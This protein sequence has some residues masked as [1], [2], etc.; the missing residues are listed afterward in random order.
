MIFLIRNRTIAALARD[1]R[2]NWKSQAE[3]SLAEQKADDKKDQPMTTGSKKMNQPKTSPTA[4]KTQAS[5]IQKKTEP[6]TNEKNK[7][8]LVEDKLE[9]KK[10]SASKMDSSNATESKTSPKGSSL[11]ATKSLIKDNSMLNDDDTKNSDRDTAKSKPVSDKLEPNS[12][13]KNT[14]SVSKKELALSKT[15]DSS[16]AKTVEN[17]KLTLSK[18]SSDNAMDA[19]DSS[20]VTDVQPKTELV[21]KEP[22]MVD[23]SLEKIELKSEV[24]VADI[25]LKKDKQ[26]NFESTVS[27]K[28]EKLKEEAIPDT[29][30]SK[31]DILKKETSAASPQ[32]D[33]LKKEQLAVSPKHEVVKK[34]KLVD[35]VL[36]K[37][38][39]GV[40]KKRKVISP[41]KDSLKN[42]KNGDQPTRVNEKII[43][44]QPAST[45]SIRKQDYTRAI[46]DEK[47][48]VE[49]CASKLESGDLSSEETLHLLQT[50][51]Q[52]SVTSYTQ[53]RW[54]IV[55]SAQLPIQNS[56]N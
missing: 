39:A 49:E 20:K 37:K 41:N 29:A 10:D 55:N 9:Q 22:D 15:P 42:E 52:V 26:E 32:Q 6:R 21:K 45:S 44:P 53:S 19:K 27:P 51:K 50:L 47:S 11:D 18:E 46:K 40:L 24:K 12:V 2:R 38:G 14:E 48:S 25:I 35:A 7:K 4:K 13:Q 16:I 3:T 34:E 5:I 31:Q 54:Y 56:K 30:S 1:I 17:V 23:A 8:P 36:P 43:S 33:S 28:Q